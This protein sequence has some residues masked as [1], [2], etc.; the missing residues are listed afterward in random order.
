MIKTK[1]SKPLTPPQQ[2]AA[3]IALG[4]LVCFLG[5]ASYVLKL[6]FDAAPVGDEL[7]ELVQAQVAAAA[8]GEP[9]N[10]DRSSAIA[11]K[12]N[13]LNDLSRK[14]DPL[15]PERLWLK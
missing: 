9:E 2:T 3:F 8:R 13:Y 11:A 12:V 4:A 10:V 14:I 7:V 15:H 5:Q 6:S 1:A